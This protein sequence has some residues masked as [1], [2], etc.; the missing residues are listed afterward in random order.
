[1]NVIISKKRWDFVLEELRL[2]SSHV[3][4]DLDKKMLLMPVFE[5]HL[6]YCNCKNTGYVDVLLDD[7]SND[8]LLSI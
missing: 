6:Y 5:S 2:A 8:S 4:V 1:M 7:E 3:I